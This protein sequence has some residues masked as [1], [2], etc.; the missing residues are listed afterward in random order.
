MC[1][2]WPYL[3]EKPPISVFPKAPTNEHLQNFVF[4]A[5]KS[6]GA[7]LRHKSAVTMDFVLGGMRAE[8]YLKSGRGVGGRGE[9]RPIAADAC[10]TPRHLPAITA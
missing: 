3:D 7:T 9:R 8:G 4:V 5:K 10:A 2:V 1:A 6:L